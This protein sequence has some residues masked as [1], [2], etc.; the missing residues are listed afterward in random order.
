VILDGAFQHSEEF[1]AVF[2]TGVV[3]DPGFVLLY[4]FHVS[5]SGFRRSPHALAR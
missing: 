1:F 4:H 2:G 5:V 3:G